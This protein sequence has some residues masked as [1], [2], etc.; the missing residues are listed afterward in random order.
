MGNIGIAARGTY[1]LLSGSNL[2]YII[3]AS[4][5][6]KDVLQSVPLLPAAKAKAQPAT[7]SPLQI[8]GAATSG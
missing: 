3:L 8:G 1:L 7:S 2:G 6:D 4:P 5:D